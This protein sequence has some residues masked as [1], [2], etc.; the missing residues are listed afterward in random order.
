MPITPRSVAIT[1]QLTRALGEAVIGLWSNLPQD[2]QVFK[3]AVA[4]Q[5]EAIKSHFPVSCE[6]G[7][8][9]LRT[10]LAALAK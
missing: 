7:R 10:L 4:S 8:S 2:V 9:G 6:I 5:G 1:D 3:E